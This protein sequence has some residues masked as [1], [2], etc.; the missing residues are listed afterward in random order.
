MSGS[1]R[2]HLGVNKTGYDVPFFENAERLIQYRE[3]MTHENHVNEQI[4]YSPVSS[5]TSYQ[6]GSTIKFQIDRKADYC[7]QLEFIMTRSEDKTGNPNSQVA[8]LDFEGY[9]SI[10]YVD[11][12]SD[13]VVPF[14]FYMEHLLIDLLQEGDE[15]ARHIAADCTY[16]YRLP[17][18]RVQLALIPVTTVTKLRLPFDSHDRLIPAHTFASKLNID[19]TLKPLKDCCK[20]SFASSFIISNPILRCQGTHLEK[21]S[22]D[23]DYAKVWGQFGL[24]IKIKDREYHKREF[25]DATAGIKRIKLTNIKN[26]VYNMKFYIRNNADLTNNAQLATLNFQTCST[27]WLEENH[28]RITPVFEFNDPSQPTTSDYSVTCNNH[29]MFP[30]GMKGLL[31]GD[32][33]F[34]PHEFVRASEKD[35]FGSRLFSGYNNLELVLNFINAPSQAQVI[36]VIGEIHQYAIWHNGMLR[37]YVK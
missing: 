35:C 22:K 13:N 6:Y 20:N 1:G 28:N 4:D 17:Q 37:P 9:Q 29:K 31:I 24:P 3:P 2:Q 19:I 36:D 15:N 23:E 18:E 33:P 26:A 27:F 14:R 11:V 5:Q 8:F 7:G 34:C 16:G 12:Y 32:I 10:D 25:I 30:H 21:K